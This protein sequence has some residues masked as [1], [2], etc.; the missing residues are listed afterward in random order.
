MDKNMQTRLH[1]VITRQLKELYLKALDNTYYPV[2]PLRGIPVE[3]IRSIIELLGGTWNEEEYLM[4]RKSSQSE[5]IEEELCE[6][7]ENNIQALRALP[8][9]FQTHLKFLRIHP[10]E[11]RFADAL[12][13]WLTLQEELVEV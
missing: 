12:E 8:G 13:L 2:D 10:K 6:L 9:D 7:T 5:S 11:S 3:D 4:Q 1:T